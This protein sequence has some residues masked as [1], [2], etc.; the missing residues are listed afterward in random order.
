MRDLCASLGLQE[1][2]TYRMT[3][4]E[5][6]ARRLL[7]GTPPNDRPYLHIANP[8]VS[9]RNVMRQSLLSSVLEVVERNTRLRERMALFEISPVFMGSETD[10]L[11]EE[12]PRLV[13]L[14]CG[15][16]SLPGWQPADAAPMDFYDLKGTVSALLEGL[17]V[18]EVRYA[19]AQH[20]SFHPGKCAQ[21]LAGEHSV[22]VIGELHPQVRANYALPAAPVLAADFD[23]EAILA[24]IPT[25]HDVSAVP[26]YPPVLED[27]AVVVDEALPAERVAQV[28]RAAGGKTVLDLRLF[29][30]YRGEQVGPGRKAWLTA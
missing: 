9:D 6:E 1:V 13:I 21:V 3:S 18:P 23:L 28:I 2:I 24:A 20:P 10:D 19:P 7:A 22:G 15:P 25:H 29:D 26:A 11:P 14:L 27:L 4:P 17:K 16:R 12:Q 8:I 5:R 30:V